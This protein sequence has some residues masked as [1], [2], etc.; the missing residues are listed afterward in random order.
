VSEHLGTGPNGQNVLGFLCSVGTLASLDRIYPERR[1]T[2]RWGRCGAHWR[3]VWSL[4]GYLTDN[5][6]IAALQAYLVARRAAPEFAELGDRLPVAPEKFREFVQQASNHALIDR[7]MADF[8][9]AFGCET[10]TNPNGHDIQDTAWRTVNTGQQCF[11]KAIRAVQNVTIE[12]VRE[13]LFGPWCYRDAKPSLRWDPIDTRDGA[14][15]GAAPTDTEILVV[16]GANALASE[17]LS[18][19]P[20]AP[21]A[22]G[23]LTT[24]FTKSHGDMYFS[25]PVWTG[26][27]SISVLRSLLGYPELVAVQ[28][29]RESLRR[30]GIEAV[31]RARRTETRGSF[32]YR[33]FSAAQPA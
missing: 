1:P 27:I 12:Q 15:R 32:S 10:L 28:P 30:M 13:A 14:T 29:N 21:T 9:A 24:G 26:A 19:F 6:L 25:W 8:A 3:P 5:D 11:L 18:C 4:A 7:T 23:L 20:T 33:N 22:K 17:A 16:R 2:L 31:Y